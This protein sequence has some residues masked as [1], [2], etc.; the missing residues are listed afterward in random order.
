MVIKK[1]GMVTEIE[2]N[3]ILSIFERRNALKEL[4]MTLEQN[5]LESLIED[6]LD[7]KVRRD[8]ENM[9][10]IFQGWW[11]DKGEKYQ[12]ESIENGEWEINFKTHEI[13]LKESIS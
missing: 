4:Q 3:E 10:K 11:Q 8:L 7:H 1:V 6:T 5:S 12:W 13:Y 2:K 9:E